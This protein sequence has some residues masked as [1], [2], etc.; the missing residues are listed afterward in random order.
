MNFSFAIAII[1]WNILSPQLWEH[2]FLTTAFILVL[3]VTHRQLKSCL[4]YDHSIFQ[5]LVYK[6]EIEIQNLDFCR[7]NVKSGGQITGYYTKGIW[8]TYNLAMAGN[9]DGFGIWIYKYIMIYHMQYRYYRY[10]SG[11]G[12]YLEQLTK[13]GTMT[14]CLLVTHLHSNHNE[15]TWTY[16]GIINAEKTVFIKYLDGLCWWNHPFNHF[17]FYSQDTNTQ[18]LAQEPYQKLHSCDTAYSNQIVLG[19]A[20]C[21]YI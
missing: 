17:S 18:K 10:R 9:T 15:I 13:F 11:G 6:P 1:W 3:L 20:V 19:F 21:Y 5:L 14:P 12:I 7:N 4:A 2:Y 16:D 8:S